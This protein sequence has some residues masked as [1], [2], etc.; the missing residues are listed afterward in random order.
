ML[1]VMVNCFV[2]TKYFA[3]VIAI[4]I[5]C[6]HAFTLGISESNSPDP[7]HNTSDNSVM[8]VII[9]RSANGKLNLFRWKFGE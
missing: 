6:T 1:F 3:P 5:L 9:S 8:N 4:N 2:F 7:F